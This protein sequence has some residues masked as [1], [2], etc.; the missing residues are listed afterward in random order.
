MKQLFKYTWLMIIPMFVIGMGLTSCDDDENAGEPVIHYV[1]ASNPLSADSLIA[2]AFLG[3]L[4]VI[5]GENL[6][7]TRELW[8]NNQEALLTPTYI[9]NTSIFVNVPNKAPSEVTN[10]IRLVFADGSS[11]QYEFT[12]EISEPQLDFMRSEYAP[13]GTTTRISGDF[14]FDPILVRFTGGAEAE[15]TIVDQNNL[16]ITIPEGAEPGPITVITNFGTTESSFHYQDQRNIFLNY[17][18]LNADGSW[19][20]GLYVTDEHSLDGNYLK[21]SGTYSADAP[22]EE[23]PLGDNHYESQFWG[24]GNGRPQASLI[25]GDPDNYVLK[26]EVKVIEWYASVLNIC[27]APWNNAGNQEIWGNDLN[28]RAIYAPWQEADATFDTGDEWITVVIP[29]SEFMYDMGVTDIDVEYT[30]SANKFNT[31]NAGSLSLWMLGAPQADN[32]PFE[33][34]VDNMRIV[35]K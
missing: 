34:Y 17:D 11:Y 31:D 27:F 21:L 15:V 35:E 5:I 23:G 30:V 4:I 33:V 6:G 14:F 7:Q 29:I 24:E 22:R 13:V 1:R 32:S 20:P 19:R 25:P 8:F 2:G 12:V 26:F 28:P 9:T 10:E 3:D 16:D 18:D